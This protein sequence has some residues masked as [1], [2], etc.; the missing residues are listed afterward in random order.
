MVNCYICGRIPQVFGLYKDAIPYNGIK[1]LNWYK[2]GSYNSLGV[3]WEHYA[4]Y[5]GE[6]A[7]KPIYFKLEEL[8]RGIA[9]DITQ[10]QERYYIHMIRFE[11][12]YIPP[13]FD[14]YAFL[15]DGGFIQP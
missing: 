5:Y 7:V 13:M 11:Q 6:N 4:L 3:S 10:Y 8:P 15:V 9:I 2:V 12:D 1:I 14:L